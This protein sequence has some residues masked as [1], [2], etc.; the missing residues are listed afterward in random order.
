L[1]DVVLTRLY[2]LQEQV[3]VLAAPSVR[4]MALLP[5]AFALQGL[6]TG[7]LVK[8]GDTAS[9]GTAKTLNLVTAVTMLVLMLR[10]TSVVGSVLAAVAMSSGAVVET[11]WLFWRSRSA[12]ASLA[13]PKEE[14][15]IVERTRFH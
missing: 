15:L 10:N 9:V 6:L 11:L 2:G 12:T 5:M 1:L 7:L 13:V 8:Q 4:T 14:I 3:A